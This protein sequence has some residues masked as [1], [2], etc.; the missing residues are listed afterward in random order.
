MLP[1]PVGVVFRAPDVLKRWMELHYVSLSGALEFVDERAVARVHV[2][3]AEGESEELEAGSDLAAAAAESLRAL[4]RH[5]V[6]AVPLR[7][8]EITGLALSS[9]FLVERDRVEGLSRR[10]GRAEVDAHHL[11]RFDSQRALGALRLRPH[12]VRRLTECFVPSAEPGTARRRRCAFGATI[13][14]PSSGARRSSDPTKSSRACAAPRATDIACCIA[15]AAAAWPTSTS[16]SKSQLAR[17]VVIKVLHP[18]LGARRRSCRAFSARGGS[19]GEARASA[20]LRHP[21]LRRDAGRRVHGDAVLRGRLARRPDSEDA[22]RRRRRAR[23]RS[24]RRSRARLDYAHRRGVVHRDVKPDNVLFDED[25]NAVLT[26]FGIATARFHGRLT[27]SGRAM[28]TPHYMSP[29]QAMGKL[30]D[31]RSDIYAVGIMLVR[32]ARRLSAVR[33]RRRVLRELQAGA[34]SAGARRSK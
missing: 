8:E 1:A 3:R 27:A 2:V 29:E 28:G 4:R 33:R 13:R 9:A 31:G 26:D 16:P 17:R 14:C 11:L 10:R 34:R 7:L 6:A 32:G 25:G 24:P 5:A 23:R 20:H 18:H 21:R 12:A 19:G 22:L 15:S 30:V